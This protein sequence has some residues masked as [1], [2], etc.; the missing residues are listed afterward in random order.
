MGRRDMVHGKWNII[1]SLGHRNK[2]EA[3]IFKSLSLR[4]SVDVNEILK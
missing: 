3:T 2:S 4:G 1:V